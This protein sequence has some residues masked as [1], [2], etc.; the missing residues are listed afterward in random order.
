MIP[1]FALERTQ[2]LLLDLHQLLQTGAIPDVSIFI[3]SPL[4]NRITE[5][6]ER[7]AADLEDMHC[8]NVFA[9]PAFH[10]VTD[11]AQSIA[12]NSVSGAIIMAA[13]G[14]CEGGRIR[15]HLIHNLH[16]KDSTVLF[17]GY[18]AAGSLGRV[19]LE[20]A[21]RVRISGNDVR[22][23]AQIRSIDSYSA[24]ADQLQLLDW[25]E[26]RSPISGS[27]FLD[28]GEAGALE[29]LR[30]E[31]S[32][33]HPNLSVRVPEIG[34]SYQLVPGQ[35]AKRLRPGRADL[36]GQLG[37][38]WQNIY[39][40]FATSLKHQLAELDDNSQREDA[41]NKMRAVLESYRAYRTGRKRD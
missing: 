8:G 5:V 30:R 20:G 31:L 13:S 11:V 37:R 38:D 29:I 6:F 16:R 24:H 10:F 39:A 28:H 23:R 22:V 15:H 18:Q 32:R 33:R 7:H 21:Q 19:I 2:E 12:L 25:I 1:V 4:A 26:E 9:H 40:D 14:M 41:L 35:P 34:E 17:V 36:S 27:L 3:D